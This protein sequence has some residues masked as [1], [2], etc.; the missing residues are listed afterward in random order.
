M[1]TQYKSQLKSIVLTLRHILEGRYDNTGSWHPGDLE[2]RLAT[3]GIRR[4]REALPLEQLS[5]LS[6]EDLR[7]RLIVDTFIQTSL[8]SGRSREEAFSEFLQEAAYTWANRLI[9]LRCMEA[10]TLI[11]EIIIQKDNYGG[12]SLKHHRLTR[13]NPEVCIGEDDGLYAALSAEFLERAE[14]LPLLFSPDEPVIALKPGV[15]AL[16][17]CIQLLSAEDE[18]FTAPDAL[19]WAYQYWNT[20][21]KRRVSDNIRTVK[22]AKIEKGDIISYTQ[23][24]TEPYMVKFLVQNS[25]GALWMAMYPDSRLCESWEYYVRDADRALMKKKSLKWISFL[26]PCVGSGHFLLMA[27][28]LLYAMYMEEGELKTPGEIC[29]AILSQNLFGID[30]DERAIQ[31]AACALYMKAKEKDGAFR[32]TRI[33]LTATNIHTGANMDHLAAFLDKHPEDKP[34]HSTLQ[35]IFESLGHADELGALLQIEEPVEKEFR[36]LKA[37]VDEEKSGPPKQKPLF[38]KLEKPEQSSL[39]LGVISYEEWKSGLLARL[40]AHFKEEFASAD[41][42]SRFFGE[43][44]GK[45]LSLFDFLSRRYDVVATNP[46]YM[47][48]KNMGPVVKQYVEK[49]FTAGKRDLYAAFILRCLELAQPET[50]RVAMVTQQ[51][52]MFLRSFADLRAL[53]EE[54][55]KKAKGFKG[56][57]REMSIETLAHLGPGAFGEISGE[58]VNIVLFTLSKSSPMADHRLTAF[59]LIGSKNPEEKARHLRTEN[60]YAVIRPLQTR[61]LT[62]PQTPVCY[63]L[64][65]SFFELLAG[66]TLGSVAILAEP[67]T[68]GANDRFVRAFWETPNGKRWMCASRGGGYAK[69]AGYSFWEMEWELNGS[70]IKSSEGSY[71]RNEQLMFC[72]GLT[73]TESARGSLGIRCLRIGEAFAKSGPGIFHEIPGLQSL[74]GVL[75]CRLCSYL[76]RVTARSF[77]F[78]VGSL[79][80]LPMPINQVTDS[81]QFAAVCIDL[82]RQIVAFDPTERSF[83]GIPASRTPLTKARWRLAGNYEAVAPV[84]HTLEGLSEREVFNAYGIDGEDLQAVLAETGTPA[85]WFPLIAGFDAMPPLSDGL[86]DILSRVID[87]LQTHERR[88]PEIQELSSLKSRLRAHYEAGPGAR[89]EFDDTDGEASND[90]DEE[91]EQVPVGARIPIPTETFLEELSQRIEIHPISIYWLL[92]EGIEQEGWRCLPEEQRLTKDR[93]TVLILRLLGHRWPKQIEAGEAVPDWADDDG[94]IPL[95]EGT[96]EVTLNA[97]IRGRLAADCGDERVSSEENTFED[98]IGKPLAE[99][100]RKDFFRHH[101]SQ[102]KKR[103]IA[104]H[105]S[106]TKWASRPRQDAAFECLIYYQKT[107]GDLLPKLKNQYVIPLLKRLEMEQRSLE[108][109]NGGVTSEQKEKKESQRYRIQELKDFV[110]VLTEISASGFGPKAHLTQLRQYAINDAMLCLKARWL[111]RLSGVIHAGPLAN[112][113]DQADKTSLHE[114]FPTWVTDAVINLDYYCAKIVPKPPL[115]KTMDDDP[116]AKD[117]ADLICAKSDAMLTEAMRC[118]CAVWWK[119]FDATILKPISEKIRNAK[120]ELQSLKEQFRHPKGDYDEQS[121]MN[122]K[123]NAMKSDINVWQKELTFKSAR[124]KA[125]RYAIE[126]WSCPEALTWESWL[127]EQPMYDQLSSLNGKRPPP[128]TVAEFIRQ[129][130][131][132]QPD[133]ND[134]VRVNIA[135]LQKAGLLAADVLAGKDVCDKAIADRAAWRDDER[136]WCRQGKLPKPG[137]W[138]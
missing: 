57:L 7:V 23:L 52:W 41:F 103:P 118:A 9:A 73:Y 109:A 94:I 129:E 93:F 91:S 29:E 135:P 105:I 45:G 122:R 112:W 107:D 11:D 133:I 97:R 48:S 17:K 50:G 53:D 42:S 59:R 111:K 76:L 22:G 101:F 99:W 34:F 62:I 68:T 35:M 54:K 128:Q 60:H 86:L 26:D 56:V 95:M 64:R 102:F 121:D 84:L 80:I 49:H 21:E 110:V 100:I 79:K 134:G 13:Q 40:S 130:S 114:D 15:A 16:K 66:R 119:T 4:N 39:P 75:N 27:F 18:I 116:T 3:L 30:I 131:L 33:N 43:T 28:D 123:I 98:I 126:S 12:R 82:K 14:E 19:G 108:N 137:W 72:E 92:K 55:L 117:L 71:V 25:L 120:K 81:T 32:P 46:P 138:E 44:A 83:G 47:G 37:L 136:R 127:A 106:S 104:W 85:G 10:R 8:Q 113:R 87:Y 78:S 2:E 58:I 20:E 69:W 5:H 67:S 115:E 125:V 88:T 24:Y 70:R 31:I 74:A 6:E 96:D 90:E 77:M 51:S 63:W 36:L 61:F 38:A 132:Y 124:G 1:E 89:E 65:E